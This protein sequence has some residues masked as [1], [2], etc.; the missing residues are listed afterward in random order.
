[1]MIIK[2]SMKIQF[3]EWQS[4]LFIVW[5]NWV[6]MKLT[7]PSPVQ[8][9]NIR[10]KNG[11]FIQEKKAWC[12]DNEGKSAASFYQQVA[13]LVPDMF[14]N[15]YLT[16]NHKNIINSATSEAREEISTHLE[17]WNFR[18]CLMYVWLNLKAIHFY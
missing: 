3:T 7:H 15:Y 11:I 16:K 4:T 6:L 14:C 2:R 5:F 1:M 8:Y 12:W 18:N 9:W 17:S 10:S 13:A